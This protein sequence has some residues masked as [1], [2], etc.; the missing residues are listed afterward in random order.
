VFFSLI[1]FSC[2]QEALISHDFK[3]FILYLQF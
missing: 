3:A 2:S 1:V